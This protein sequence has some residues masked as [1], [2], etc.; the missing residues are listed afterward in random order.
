MCRHVCIWLSGLQPQFIK[1]AGILRR[2]GA[3]I[4]AVRTARTPAPDA[5]VSPT[6]RRTEQDE[7][8]ETHPHPIQK[9]AIQSEST[10]AKPRSRH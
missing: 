4:A 7:M 5:G 8:R 3:T 2:P 9:S 10:R 1:A 6:L